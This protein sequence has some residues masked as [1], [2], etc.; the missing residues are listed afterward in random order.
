MTWT[1]L[2][3]SVAG[4]SHRARN[5]PCQDAFRFRVFGSVAEWLVIAVADGAGSAAHSEIGANLACEEFVRRVEAD[6]CDAPFS[7]DRMIALFADVRGALVAKAESLG[8]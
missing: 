4:T 1:A 3:D 7:Q 8:V 2:G 6:V 5:C